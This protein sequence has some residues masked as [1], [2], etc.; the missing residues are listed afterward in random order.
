M[1][2]AIISSPSARARQS[3][4]Q[5][6]SFRLRFFVTDYPARFGACVIQLPLSV[7]AFQSTCHLDLLVVQP[8]LI[9]QQ[10][11]PRRTPVPGSEPHGLQR[12]AGLVSLQKPGHFGGGC[13]FQH[14]LGVALSQDTFAFTLGDPP[15]YGAR[16]LSVTLAC[17]LK[18]DGEVR[19]HRQSRSNQSEGPHGH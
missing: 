10:P 5:A 17:E 18:V 2:P 11:V 16:I 13:L 6:Y 7:C 9:P 4:S 19:Q 15:R 1:A 8:L 12:L 3:S 14:R